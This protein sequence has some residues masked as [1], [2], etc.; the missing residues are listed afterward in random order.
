VKREKLSM[1]L[2]VSFI[3]VFI[4][5]LGVQKAEAWDPNG[6][7]VNLEENSGGTVR[8]EIN[9]PLIHGYGDCSPT[10]CDWGNADYTTRLVAIHDSGNADR[11]E[12]MA[13][14]GFGFA[15]LLIQISPHPENP[16]YIILKTSNL[17][18]LAGDPRNNYHVIEYMKR[19]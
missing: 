3:F 10:P 2:A 12:Y 5:W 11:D 1:I 18:D 16:D 13:L 19:Q 8:L 9:F 6:T 17:Y 4:G 7:W 15:Y 14:W